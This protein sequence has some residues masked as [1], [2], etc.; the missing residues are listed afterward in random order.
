MK[1]FKLSYGQIVT[2]NQSDKFVENEMTI[3][4]LPANIF[5]ETVL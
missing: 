3:E 2:L 1:I 5:L 4:L